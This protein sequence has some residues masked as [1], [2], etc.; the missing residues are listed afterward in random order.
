MMMMMMM[1]MM[2]QAFAEWGRFM[3]A[4]Y[5]KDDTYRRSD[6]TLRYLGYWTDGGSVT[7]FHKRNTR[8]VFSVFYK[9]AY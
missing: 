4:Y 1:M 7:L 9:R 8:N 5:N 6:L 3:R 2:I